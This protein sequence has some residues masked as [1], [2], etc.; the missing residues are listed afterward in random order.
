MLLSRVQRF[1]DIDRRLFCT[2]ERLVVHD[3]VE[4]TD[5]SLRVNNGPFYVCSSLRG[6][7]R[8][9]PQTLKAGGPFYL[10]SMP[11]EVKNP[12]QGVNV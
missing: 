2:L 3:L 5:W 6:Q 8:H 1:L 12:T 7:R 10:V 9:H 4:A 11:G